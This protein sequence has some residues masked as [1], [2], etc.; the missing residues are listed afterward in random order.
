LWS[1][2]TCEVDRPEATPGAV[3][4]RGLDC[5]AFWVHEGAVWLPCNDWVFMQES[6]FV[7]LAGHLRVS[8]FPMFSR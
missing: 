4:A 5:S 8:G 1:R 6:I 3:R 7:A 2:R